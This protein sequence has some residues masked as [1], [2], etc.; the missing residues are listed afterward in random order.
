VEL[1][2]TADAV[3]GG[4]AVRRRVAAVALAALG[5]AAAAGAPALAQEPTGGTSPEIGT[6]P[7]TDAPDR[8]S[9]LAPPPTANLY[10]RP[11]PRIRRLACRSACGAAGA[12][13]PGSLVRVRGR[14]LAPLDEVVFL[15]AEG[16]G[17]RCWRACRAP[18]R[19]GRSRSCAPT[20]RARRPRRTR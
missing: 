19:Q 6:A 2:G 3:S 5:L 8:A 7:A 16:D 17:A 18:R 12:A 4:V 15:G 9:K 11:A 10:G 20:G 1:G 14:N 13:R